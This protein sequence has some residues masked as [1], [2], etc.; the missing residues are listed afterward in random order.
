MKTTNSLFRRVAAIVCAVIAVCMLAS[1]SD[2]EQGSASKLIDCGLIHEPEFGGVYITNT[3]DEFN[4]LGFEYGDSVDIVFS[5]GYILNDQPYY[6]GYYTENGKSLL[7][8]YPGYDYIKA[9]IN[10]GDDL[11]EVAGLNENDTATITL[12]ERGK[13]LDIQ[14]ARN[15]SYTDERSEF[16]SDEVFANFRSVKAGNISANTLYRSASPCDDQHNRATYVNALIEAAGIQCIVDLADSDEKIHG[17]IEDPEFNCPYFLSL[18]ENGLVIPLSMNT[19]FSSDTFKTKLSAG[20]TAMAEQKGPYLV[21]CTEGKDRTGFV[22]M[23]LEALCGASY[24][25]IV[26]DYMITYDNYYKITRESD[27]DRYTV[28]VEHVLDPMIYALF[29]DREIDLSTA[30]LAAGAE[31]FLQSAGMDTD[32]IAGLKAA[33]TAE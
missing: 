24:D 31:N 2:S 16:A 27:P 33:L 19:N 8:A 30:D 3:I 21:H 6:N 29:D 12:N 26:D 15:I 17:Y 20:L 22:C 7:V 1:C 14:N 4:A 25:E 9:A 13:Y 32:R 11:W 28:I 18:Y 23:L 10:N 5:N